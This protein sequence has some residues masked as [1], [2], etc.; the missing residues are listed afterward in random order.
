[1]KQTDINVAKAMAA[2]NALSVAGGQG[3]NTVVFSDRG[4]PLV[5]VSPELAAT[6]GRAGG[7]YPG[8]FRLVVGPVLK[9]RAVVEAINAW[10]AQ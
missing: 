10:G 7:P 1:M 9:R 2:H 6:W 3:G 4:E 8:Q 5:V